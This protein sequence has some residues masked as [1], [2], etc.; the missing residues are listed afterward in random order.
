MSPGRKEELGT[1]CERNERASLQNCGGN[2]CSTCSESGDAKLLSGD[3]RIA[4]L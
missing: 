4:S 3:G 1:I 2:V